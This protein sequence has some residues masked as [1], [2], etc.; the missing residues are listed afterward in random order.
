MADRN[1]KNLIKEFA[2]L[3]KRV[4]ED[5]ASMGIKVEEKGDNMLA[6]GG[7]YVVHDLHAIKNYNQVLGSPA[8]KNMEKFLRKDLWKD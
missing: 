7:E 6:L 1:H 2:D 4:K 8:Y 5:V 3:E